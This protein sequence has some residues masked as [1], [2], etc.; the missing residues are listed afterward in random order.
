MPFTLLSAGLSIADS[1][2][3]SFYRSEK[4]SRKLPVA[5]TEHSLTVDV[6]N[7]LGQKVL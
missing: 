2:I 7:F 1:F 5:K 3:L 6:W 4:K